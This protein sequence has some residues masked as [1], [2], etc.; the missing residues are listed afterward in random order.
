MLAVA[1]FAVSLPLTSPEP[2]KE[3]RGRGFGPFQAGSDA[4]RDLAACSGRR[5]LGGR[6]S[7]PDKTVQSRLSYR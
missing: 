7:N 2:G 3:E 4:Q 5:W 6:D 1:L